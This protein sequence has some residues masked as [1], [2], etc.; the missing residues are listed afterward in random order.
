LD[1]GLDTGKNPVRRKEAFGKL[2]LTLNPTAMSSIDQE[3][4]PSARRRMRGPE[5]FLSERELTFLRLACTEKT[6]FAIAREMYVSERTVDGYRD[7]LFRK[8]DVSSR[9]GLV[10]YALRNG[11]VRL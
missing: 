6:Y 8:L 10:L 5:V 3:I 7:S 4:F 2:F 1:G 11:I 9:V